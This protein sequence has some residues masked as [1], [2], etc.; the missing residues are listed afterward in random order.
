MRGLKW[1]VAGALAVPLAH[2]VMLAILNAA[3]MID[4]A[5]FSMEATKPL[6]VP[7]LVSLSFWGGVWGVILLLVIGRLRGP[8]F[9]IAAIVFG[10]LAPTLVAGFVVAPLKGQASGG[11]LQ[12]AM[13]GFLVNGAWGLGTAA[14]A[15]MME[16]WRAT[17]KNSR[18]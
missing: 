8:A 2:Q 14:L 10:A 3:G 18:T 15:R 4:R 13:M 7:S 5:P 11:N 17:S 9:W 16:A 6:G 1:F 12:M